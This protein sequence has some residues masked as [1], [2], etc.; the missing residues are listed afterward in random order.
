[1][2]LVWLEYAGYM[3]GICALR[4]LNHNI[5]AEGGLIYP[6][7]NRDYIAESAI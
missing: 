2:S 5:Q 6:G 7:V 3:H 1:M 4:T